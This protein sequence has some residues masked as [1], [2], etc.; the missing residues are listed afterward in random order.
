MEAVS[1]IHGESP[2][3]LSQPHSGT[4][5]PR[6]MANNLTAAGQELADTD[7]HIPR[8]YDGLIDNVTIV[9][10]NFSRQV[11]D[12]N[13]DPMGGSLYPGQTTTELVPLTRFDGEPIWK[14]PP[15]A[16]Q[17]QDHRLS[18]HTGYHR[19]LANEIARVKKIHGV[20]MLYD[21]HSIRSHIPRLFEGTLPDLNIG[22]NSGESC[23]LEIAN[24]VLQLCQ[25]HPLFSHV[26]NGRFR[27]GWITRHYGKPKDGVHAI[28]MELAQRSYLD[29]EETPPAYCETKAAP[30]RALLANL[31]ATFQNLPSNQ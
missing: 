1:V 21:C 23:D 9:R 31:L 25:N 28:Q 4:W 11:I 19:A 6:E 30:M 12:A 16:K 22:T 7:W 20:A 27:G 24:T 26:I 10:A 15:D 17:T 3:I 14:Q 13:R 5:L 18:F 2:L 29:S 8:L